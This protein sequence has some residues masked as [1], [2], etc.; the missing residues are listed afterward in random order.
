MTVL[1]TPDQM[2]MAR[3]LTLRAMLKL[4]VLGMSRSKSPS[5]YSILKKE[6]GCTG[7]RKAVL[8][9]LNAWRDQLLNQGETK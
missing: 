2:D 4:E 1:T 9:E 3:L 6:Y 5:A 8:E 7:T